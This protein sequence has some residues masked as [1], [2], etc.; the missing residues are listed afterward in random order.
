MEDKFLSIY[1]LA[2]DTDFSSS[3]S[4]QGF[5]MEGKMFSISSLALD[6][7]FFVFSFSIFLFLSSRHDSS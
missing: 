4:S 2:Q 7:D 1:S 6:K 5:F 3:T